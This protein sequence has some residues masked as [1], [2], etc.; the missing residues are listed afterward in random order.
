MIAMVKYLICYD[1]LLYYQNG[2]FISGIG[3]LIDI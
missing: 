3:R 2:W 1:T